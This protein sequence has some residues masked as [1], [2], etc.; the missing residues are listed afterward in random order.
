MKR[1]FVIIADQPGLPANDIIVAETLLGGAL[2][3]DMESAKKAYSK[4]L[5]SEDTDLL[6]YPYPVLWRNVF[7]RDNESFSVSQA[8]NKSDSKRPTL[9]IVPIYIPARLLF[10]PDLNIVTDKN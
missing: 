1:M 8:I 10:C 3:E 9:F 5:E 6:C 7:D 4:E 2:F